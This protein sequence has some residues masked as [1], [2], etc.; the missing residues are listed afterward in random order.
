[1]R[2]TGIVSGQHVT[3]LKIS[4][5]YVE[6]SA[7]ANVSMFNRENESFQRGKQLQMFPL[8]SG[9]NVG[10]PQTGSNMASPY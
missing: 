7:S 10:V 1:M 9:R 8:A 2:D 5:Q 4:N 3:C 6:R